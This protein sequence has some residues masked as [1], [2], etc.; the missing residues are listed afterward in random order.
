MKLVEIVRTILTDKDVYEQAV[1]FGEQLGKV[2]VRAGD[3][4]GLVLDAAAGH[5]FGP[6]GRNLK[7]VPA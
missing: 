2:P 5:L 3:K 6:D 7:A 4:T 1:E